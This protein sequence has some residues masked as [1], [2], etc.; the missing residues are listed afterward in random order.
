MEIMDI[1]LDIMRWELQIN[2]DETVHTNRATTRTYPQFWTATAK[3]THK[4]INYGGGEDALTSNVTTTK[5]R[6]YVD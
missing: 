5:K 3:A 4:L 1:I 6:T 2:N